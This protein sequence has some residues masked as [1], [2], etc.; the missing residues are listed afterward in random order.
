MS[1]VIAW[2]GSLARVFGWRF[3]I[4]PSYAAATIHSFLLKL[5][6]L[7]VVIPHEFA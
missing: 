4:S 6:A 3:P 1:V 5:G 2:P 7:H